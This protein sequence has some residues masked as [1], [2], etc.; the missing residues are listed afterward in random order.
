[1]ITGY[2]ITFKNT[3]IKTSA[4]KIHPFWSVKQ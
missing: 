1:M 4:T 3:W 2:L